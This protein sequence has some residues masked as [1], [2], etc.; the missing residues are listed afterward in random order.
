MTTAALPAGD[1]DLVSRATLKLLQ[2]RLENKRCGLFRS[3]TCPQG[4][5]CGSFWQESVP[6]YTSVIMVYLLPRRQCREAGQYLCRNAAETLE[7]ASCGSHMCGIFG[8]G[9]Y[10]ALARVCSKASAFG[11]RIC[12]QVTT[13]KVFDAMATAQ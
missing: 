3:K 8:G 4:Y 10:V 12:T 11:N 7:L 13:R 5:T 2:A 6:S 1:A 9:S